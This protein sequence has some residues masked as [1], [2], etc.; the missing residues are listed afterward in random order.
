MK[1]ISEDGLKCLDKVMLMAQTG[2]PMI[3]TVNYF[4]QK[5]HETFELLVRSYNNGTSVNE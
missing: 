2:C 1:E 5:W 3:L 4:C